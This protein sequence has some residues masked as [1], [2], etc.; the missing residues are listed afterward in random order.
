MRKKVRENRYY[1]RHC[2]TEECIPDELDNISLEDI[3]KVFCP[4]CLAKGKKRKM[5]KVINGN[6]AQLNVRR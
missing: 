4:R 2:K 3:T 6:Q 5:V 1:C